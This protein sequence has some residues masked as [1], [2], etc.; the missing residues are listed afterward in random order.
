M[1]FIKVLRVHDDGERRHGL[2]EVQSELLRGAPR[3]RHALVERLVLDPRSCIRYRADASL[4]ILGVLNG[5]VR[6]NLEGCPAEVLSG[7]DIVV[8]RE[9]KPYVTSGVIPAPDD[10]THIS[11]RK[12]GGCDKQGGTSGAASAERAL[13]EVLLSR[14]VYRNTG[15]VGGLLLDALPRV[16]IVRSDSDRRCVELLHYM[17]LEISRGADVGLDRL[18]LDRLLDLLLVTVLQSWSLSSA[19]RE[20]AR[21]QACQDPAVSKAIQLLHENLGHPWTSDTLANCIGY[22]R[23]SLARRYTTDWP[24]ADVLS[25]R[26]STG[27]R[28]GAAVGARSDSR[29]GC[30][31]GWIHVTVSVQ[32]RLQKSE[33]C[34]PE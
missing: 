10:I 31:A 26:A 14:G 7:G 5:Q 11:L 33:G 25:G 17:N 16:L 3:V 4:A 1:S 30:F 13:S 22:S 19:T 23:A 6:V 28:G 24:V 21:Y 34:Q 9:P 15:L 20:P 2:R 27:S 12:S 32:H 29:G 8:L 18:L